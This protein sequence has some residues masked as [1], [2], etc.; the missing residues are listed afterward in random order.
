MKTK[1]TLVAVLSLL[2]AGMMAFVLTACAKDVTVTVNDAGTS[3]EIQTKTDQTIGD[4]LAEAQITLGDKDEVE[5]AADT[6]L[7]ED[8]TAITIKRYA[9]V[10]FVKD[11]E[12]IAVELV[13]ATVEEALKAAGVTLAEGEEAD[14][15][16]AAYVKDGMTV[17]ITKEVKVTLTDGGEKKEITTKAATVQ[18]LLD[19]QSIT[20]GADDELSEKP[21]TKLTDGMK[22]TVNRVEYKE[23]TKTETIDYTTEEQYSSSMAQGTSQVTQAGAEGE[24]EVT[25]KVKYVN[26]KEKEREVVSE[27]VTK[28]PVARIVTY[29]TKAAEQKPAGKTVVSKTPVYD[30]DGSGHG[31]YEIVY[32]DGSTD[33]QD[34]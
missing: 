2:L 24:K 31:Y 15:D 28:D 3:T 34:F 16:P 7:T 19:E 21:E 13:G 4:I 8:I 30:C 9:K 12:E 23:E 29:G 17:T 22:I 5:P 26:G 10:T 25:Y 32:S 18:A 11:G 20:L 6:K 33:H 1:R 27:K 14:A